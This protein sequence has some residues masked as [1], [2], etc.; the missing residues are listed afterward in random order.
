VRTLAG[1]DARPRARS[2]APPDSC[3]PRLE[4]RRP[5]CTAPLAPC[6]TGGPV[7]AVGAWITTAPGRLPHAMLAGRAVSAGP[8]PGSRVCDRAPGVL[9]PSARPASLAL[10]GQRAGRGPPLPLGRP[11]G[12][13]AR[14][15]GRPGGATTPS[16]SPGGE[17][18]P[19]AGHDDATNTRDSAARGREARGPGPACGG[20]RASGGDHGRGVGRLAS[21]SVA[22]LAASA[23]R[24][25]VRRRSSDTGAMAED[26]LSSAG[27]G[28]KG[29]R[30]GHR[31][32]DAAARGST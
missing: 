7:K 25:R 27:G 11:G 4:S 22:I 10:C 17:G 20:R 5:A 24:P 16:E 18:R 28:E 30:W 6:W 1:G 2:P 8:R 12:E 26:G 19:P 9:A 23:K 3:W 15:P 31:R 14:R 13:P 32:A 21:G 29:S